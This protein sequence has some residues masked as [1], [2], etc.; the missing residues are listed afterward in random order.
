VVSEEVSAEDLADR[1]V[2]AVISQIRIFTQIILALIN[3]RLHRL[4]LAGSG[5]MVMAIMRE[6]SELVPVALVARTPSPSPVSRS[7]SAT[8]VECSLKPFTT[9]PVH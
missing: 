2:Q 7:W 5:W 4:G 1:R 3:R 6:G 9:Y 8:Y